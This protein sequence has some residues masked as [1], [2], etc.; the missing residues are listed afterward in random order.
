M[1]RLFKNSTKKSKLIIIATIAILSLLYYKILALVEDP[2]TVQGCGIEY[3]DNVDKSKIDS[4]SN[5]YE[6][7]WR[8]KGGSL[9]DASCLNETTVHG[10]ISVRGENEIRDALQY[11]RTND[12]KVSMSG[13]RHSMGGHAFSKGNLVLDMT[14]FND[15]KVNEHR[16]TITVQSG[17]TWHD[18]Q[19]QL[20]PRFA[21]KAMQST[22]IFTIGGSISV[23]AHGM[24]HSIGAVENT[25]RWIRVMLPDGSIVKVSRTQNME[26]YDLIVGGYGLFGIILDAE[27]DISKNVVYE[28]SRRVVS[29]KDFPQMF[30]ESIVPNKD[31]GLMYT[32]LSTAPSSLLDESIVYIYEKAKKDISTEDIPPL[33]EVSNIKLRRFVINMA[34]FGGIAQQL[35]WWSEKYLEP[36]MESC[37]VS[38][39]QALGSGEA[40]MVA[41]NEPMHDSVPYLFNNLIKE[42]DILHEYFIPRENIVAFVDDMREI[43]KRNNT[44]LLNVSVRVVNRE[45][46]FLTYAPKEA[47]SVVLFINQRS[48]ENG[49]KKMEK[50]TQ[51]LIDATHAHD[52]RFFL[53]YQLHYTPEQLRTS[54]PQIDKFFT[55]KRRYD[56]D[57]LLTSTWYETYGT[58]L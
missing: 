22:D 14:S 50:V 21:V 47:F 33:G 20:H 42:T 6:L 29:F 35:K 3:F 32:H 24:D 27:I 7:S 18:I 17:A 55:L 25:I 40:C 43:I 10:V 45:R 23:N 54:Y 31:I 48:D 51:E 37:S 13:V 8:Q 16:Q 53:P 15:I 46:G 1:A 49:N 30:N 34:K 19:N 36:K 26:L 56:P 39:N 12:L 52:G 9:N 28:S 57:G 5:I 38:R 2:K 44:N 11:A 4:A 58:W 41:R